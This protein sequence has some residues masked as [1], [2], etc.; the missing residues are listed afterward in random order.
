MRNGLTSLCWTEDDLKDAIENLKHL[1]LTPEEYTAY[2]M[3]LSNNAYCVKMRKESIEKAIKEAIKEAI[4]EVN[5]TFIV[6]ALKR[7]KLTDEEIAD[8][9]S[10]SIEY[11]LEVKNLMNV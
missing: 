7:G 2:V 4:E 6:N 5:K 9:S 10:T 3:T 1:R 11:V 8:Y